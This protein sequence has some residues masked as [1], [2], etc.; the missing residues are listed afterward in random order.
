MEGM[1]E[2]GAALRAERERQGRSLD[3]V[4]RATHITVRYLE[5]LETGAFEAIPGEVYLKGFLRRY[6]QFLGL[7]GEELVRR[8]QDRR[9]QDGEAARESTP[10]RPAQTA[11]EGWTRTGDRGRTSR[12]VAAVAVVALAA[13]ATGW[14]VAIWS[15]RSPAPDLSPR[16]PAVS[17][18]ANQAPVPTPLPVVTPPS[19]DGS[20][21]QA[22]PD[23]AAASVRVSVKLTDRCWF[24]VVADGQLAF[25]GELAAGA[26]A[27]W[28]ARERLTVRFGNPGGV[29]LTWNGRPVELPGKDPL[30]RVFTPEAVVVP[31]PKAP[32]PAP[33]PVSPAASPPA[34]PEPPV[35]P[36]AE[37]GEGA[38]PS[39]PVTP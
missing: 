16:S 19:A 27:S 29:S 23:A 14:A 39:A 31:P 5:S 28:T 33:A 9:A 37:P 12:I 32:R 8:Y 4:Y 38:A 13:V 11:R 15:V 6:A 10:R 26:E 21:P 22:P 24:R 3:E 18:E 25:E 35:P 1:E 30:T 20:E 2:I 34:G 36:A 17:P 7:D